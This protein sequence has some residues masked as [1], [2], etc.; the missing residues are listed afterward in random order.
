MTHWVRKESFKVTQIQKHDFPITKWD[1]DFIL[2]EDNGD[3]WNTLGVE[4][5]EK[6]G[7]MAYVSTLS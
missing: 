7:V 3:T 6:V 4:E 2:H 1:N 5:N